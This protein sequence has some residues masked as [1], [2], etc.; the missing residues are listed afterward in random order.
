M[1]AAIIERMRRIAM[2]ALAVVLGS[3]TF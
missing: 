1:S 2:I 3:S